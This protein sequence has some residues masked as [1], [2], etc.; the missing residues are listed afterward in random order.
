MLK[1]RYDNAPHPENLYDFAEALER[2]GRAADARTAYA[3]FEKR[4]LKEAE[5]W[6]NA[7]RS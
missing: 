5:S 2:A 6:D 1:Q 4:A 7:N 3:E